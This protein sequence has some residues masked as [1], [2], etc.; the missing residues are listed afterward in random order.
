[1]I[2]R[3]ERSNQQ[4]RCHCVLYLVGETPTDSHRCHEMT[5]GPD[6]PFC[7]MCTGRHPDH[8]RGSFVV[9]QVLPGV[10]A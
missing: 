1:M 10:R 6:D 8:V 3:P 5:S 7:R 2:V 4:V 9:T